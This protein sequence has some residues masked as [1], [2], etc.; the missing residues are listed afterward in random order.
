MLDNY[1]S[2][3]NTYN[4]IYIITDITYNFNTRGRDV[5]LKC[6]E[7]GRVM[8][9]TMIKGRNKWSELIKTCPCQKL[10][11]QEEA[12]SELEKIL[13]NEKEVILSRVGGKYGDYKII[14]IQDIDTNPKYVMQCNQC[15]EKRTMLATLK[16]FE[17][18]NFHCTKHYIQPIKF[19]NSY[20]GRKNNRLTVIGIAKDEKKHRKFVCKCD[21]GNIKL[22]EPCFWEKGVVKSCGCLS[23]ESRLE[24]SEELDRLRRIHNGMIQRCYNP[25]SHSYTN[26]GGRGIKICEEWHDR[27]K[28]IGWALKNGYSNDL[29]IDRIDVNGNYEPSNCRWADWQTQSNNKRPS[30]EWKKRKPRE[31]MYW[32]IDGVSKTREE[33]CKEY[34]IGLPAVLYRINKKGMSIEEALKKP[35]ETLGRPRKVEINENIK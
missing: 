3:V 30:D 32:V 23:E 31:R 4:G 28:F 13:K 34:N 7:C 19:D 21:C 26:Y 17:K 24:H 18:K 35:K 5:T 29:S 27:E 15:G 11:R 10:K 33:W 2:K 20:I 22:I 16:S 25:N 1:K 9:R 14:S 12:R 8:H 6:T